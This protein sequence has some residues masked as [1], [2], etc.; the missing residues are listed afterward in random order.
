MAIDFG[1]PSKKCFI[2]ENGIIFFGY[3]SYRLSDLTSI[4]LAYPPRDVLPSSINLSFA[5]D[6]MLK[7]KIS[8]LKAQECEELLRLLE[9]RL[10]D[11]K[12][13]Q[14]IRLIER[15]RKLARKGPGEEA[16]RVRISYNGHRVLTEMKDAFMG[17]LQKWD[18]VGPVLV[19]AIALLPALLNVEPLFIF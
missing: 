6:K 2:G 12:V 8:R 17:T 7:L 18:R 3:R 19:F 5:T 11:C 10:P 4:S 14:R 9:K 1:D 15:S 13:D 16:T